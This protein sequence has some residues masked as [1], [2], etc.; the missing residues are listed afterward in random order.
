[1]VVQPGTSEA[2]TQ[3]TA[4]RDGIIEEQETFSLNFE[5]DFSTEESLSTT[6]VTVTDRDS[7]IL[8]FHVLPI[9]R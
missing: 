8:Q 4:V 6:V 7:K 9:M 5:S 3:I 2:C 1:M